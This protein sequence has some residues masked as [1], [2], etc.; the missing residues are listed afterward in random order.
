MC[1]YD[2]HVE[3]CHKYMKYLF[4]YIYIYVYVCMCICVVAFKHLYKHNKY[5][6]YTQI[7]LL[8]H[9]NIRNIL[10]FCSYY[11]SSETYD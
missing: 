3:V 5:Y 10:V 7:V 11:I 4:I 9:I 1:V 6:Y 8:F 2:L